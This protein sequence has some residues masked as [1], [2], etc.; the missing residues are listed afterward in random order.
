MWLISFLVCRWK[1]SCQI[2]FLQRKCPLMVFSPCEFDS[3]RGLI[4]SISD[5]IRKRRQGSA[6]ICFNNRNSLINTCTME[7]VYSNGGHNSS[8]LS[9]SACPLCLRQVIQGKMK[10]GV[11]PEPDPFVAFFFL[12]RPTKDRNDS[13]RN[14]LNI[15][16]FTRIGEVS[17]MQAVQQNAVLAVSELG[18]RGVSDRRTDKEISRRSEYFS[19][20]SS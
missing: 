4:C 3:G 12:C 17:H 10:A 2:I 19:G 14:T 15:Q 1:W 16:K 9:E 20:Q 7:G 5:K 13:Q 18:I 11:S 8:F 6:V